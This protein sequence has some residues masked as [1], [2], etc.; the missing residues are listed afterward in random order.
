MYLML[1]CPCF[2]HVI[3][4]IAREFSPDMVIISAGFDAAEGDPLG[5]CL[6]SPEAFGHFTKVRANSVLKICS[7][8]DL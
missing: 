7:H 8:V 5:N 2:R 6:V 4:P 1:L 3:L